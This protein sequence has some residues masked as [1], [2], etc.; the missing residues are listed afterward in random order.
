V[1]TNLADNDDD[2]DAQGEEHYEDIKL[3]VCGDLL[4]R[5]YLWHVCN[6][7]CGQNTRIWEL[8]TFD[9]HCDCSM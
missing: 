9:K 4:Y 2:D 1:S 7:C 3:E 8:Q 6:G 5:N